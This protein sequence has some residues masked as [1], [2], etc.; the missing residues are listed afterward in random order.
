MALNN[1]PTTQSD[2]LQ[3][4]ISLSILYIN[5]VCL[6][7][8]ILIPFSNTIS[9]NTNI[10]CGL[11]AIQKQSNLYV[12]SSITKSLITISYGH[13]QIFIKLLK[14]LYQIFVF[15]CVSNIPNKLYE[16]KPLSVICSSIS[17]INISIFIWETACKCRIDRRINRQKYR[18][19]RYLILDISYICVKMCYD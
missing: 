17:D 19:S 7:N 13:F 9:T 18:K 16:V 4:L 12:F 14:L 15:H 5:C 1:Y 10:Q 6:S 8:L 3:L 11:I 2:F